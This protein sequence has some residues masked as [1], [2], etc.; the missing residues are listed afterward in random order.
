MVY[1]GQTVH[2][3]MCGSLTDDLCD[4]EKFMLYTKTLVPGDPMAEC[5]VPAK[6]KE[7]RGLRFNGEEYDLDERV[8]EYPLS[9]VVVVIVLS[10]GIVLLGIC[11]LR[12]EI[13]MQSMTAKHRYFLYSHPAVCVF[14]T[15]WSFAQV[16]QLRHVRTQ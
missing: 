2:P 13:Q 7:A 8:V 4:Y 15:I 1:N 16:Y 11:L 5:K 9:L 6:G 3:P 10:S 14:V 12:K